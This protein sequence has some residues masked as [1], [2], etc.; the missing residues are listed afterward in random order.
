MN[1]KKAFTLGEVLTVFIII[2]IIATIAMTTIKPWEKAYKYA[3]MKIYNALSVSIYN[4]MTTVSGIDS[5]PSTPQAFCNALISYMNTSNNAEHSD[6]NPCNLS[7]GKNDF[8]N[9]APQLSAFQGGSNPKIRLSNGAWLWI[10]AYYDDDNDSWKPF[11]YK[12]TIGSGEDASED[13]IKYYIVYADLNGD[14]GPNVIEYNPN[15]KFR[16]LPDIVSFAVT[17]TFAVIPFGYPKVDQRYLS[18][19]IMF[20]VSEDDDEA[21][22]EGDRPSDSMTYYE[23]LVGAYGKDDNENKK[24]ITQ[25]VVETYNL[26][27]SLPEGNLFK[28]VGS[29]LDSNYGANPPVFNQAICGDGSTAAQIVA[30]NRESHCSIKVFNYN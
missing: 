19:H 11:E 29:N 27:E 2:G 13:V 6:E 22:A 28:L 20:P 8:L 24:I 30:D 25:G 17:D 9:N 12:Q 23:A 26:E 4:Y 5:F 10:G 14:R 18:A 16:R 21:T 1:N 3:Y 7:G 15:A